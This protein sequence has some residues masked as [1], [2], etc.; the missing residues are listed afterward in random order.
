[1]NSVYCRYPSLE[2][3]IIQEV[4]AVFRDGDQ[5]DMRQVHKALQEMCPA[6]NKG[7]VAIQNDLQ[8]A[9]QPVVDVARPRGLMPNSPH[10][11]PPHADDPMN[12]SESNDGS[13]RPLGLAS[14]A[15]LPCDVV[16]PPG[17]HLQTNFRPWLFL[18]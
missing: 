1:M 9:Q 16:T 2:P 4:I 10:V 14:M 8:Q 15:T 11:S 17:V 18:K 13:E 6:S 5:I 7:T 3:A 12:L